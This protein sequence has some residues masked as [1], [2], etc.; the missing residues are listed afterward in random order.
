VSERRRIGTSVAVAT[1]ALAVALGLQPISVDRILSAYVL[2]LAAIAMAALTRVLRSASELPPPSDFE[3]ALRRRVSVKMRPPELIRVEREITLGVSSAWQLH[4][5]LAPMLRE[6]AAARGVDFARRP[7][8]ARELLGGETY[9]L[10]R[11]DRAVPDD[12]AAPGVPFAR[13]RTAVESLER[14]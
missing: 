9:D 3:H 2:V 5:R 1:L 4:T 14:L 12:R 7:D 11:P 8:E 10:V 13:V 6:V